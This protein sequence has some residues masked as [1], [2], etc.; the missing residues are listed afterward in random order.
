[1]KTPSFLTSTL[2][3][4]FLLCVIACVILLFTNITIN[5]LV[6]GIITAVVGA[7]LGTH[8]PTPTNS[9]STNVVMPAVTQVEDTTTQV[10][11]TPQ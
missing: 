10:S 5:P 11:E 2:S 3:L 6:W 9:Q 7:Y 1:M 4:A 8:N